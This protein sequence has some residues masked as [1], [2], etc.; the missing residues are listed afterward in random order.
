[1]TGQQRKTFL[2]KH[3]S[4][5]RKKSD[6]QEWFKHT[7]GLAVLLRGGGSARP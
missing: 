5:Q 4:F 7:W 6:A 1:M 2:I 3:D